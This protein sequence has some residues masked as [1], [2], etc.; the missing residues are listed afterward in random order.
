[1]INDVVSCDDRG[2]VLLPREVREKYGTTFHVVRARGEIVLIPAPDDPVQ[3]LAKIGKEAGI[4][5][6][7]FLKLKQAIRTDALSELTR[8]ALRKH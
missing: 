8:H 2:R 1:M 6:T 3:E 7:S 4:S 5:R